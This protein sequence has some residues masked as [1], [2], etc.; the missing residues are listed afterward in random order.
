LKVPEGVVLVERGDFHLRFRVDKPHEKNPF[1]VREL[2]SLG[3][4]LLAFG[5]VPRSLEQVYLKIMADA[6]SPR[7]EM[8]YA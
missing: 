8:T 4:P 5:E 1:L 2:S 6:Q 3:A 7:M